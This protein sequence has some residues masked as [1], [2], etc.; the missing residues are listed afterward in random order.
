MKITTTIYSLFLVLAFMVV[1]VTNSWA[2]ATIEVMETDSAAE[3][4]VIGFFDLRERETYMQVTNIDQNPAGRTFHIQ[5]FNVGNNC[6]ENNFFDDYT[7]NDTHVYNIRDI[8]RND[9]TANTV[10]LPDDAYG[11]FVAFVVG[12]DEP[13][14]IGNLRI[15]DVNGYEYRT[16]LPGIEDSPDQNSDDDPSYFNINSESG[17]ILSDIVVF[18][19]NIKGNDNE[20]IMSSVISIWTNWEIDIIDLNEDI[21][22]CRNV[23]TACVE[24]DNPIVPQLLEEVFDE[25][26]QSAGTVASFEWGINE[27]IPS[28]KGAPLLCPGNII[29]DGVVQMNFRDKGD[30]ADKRITVFV[31]L[32][33]GN[34]RGSMDV[35]VDGSTVNND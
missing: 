22:S 33:N 13:V 30:G 28:S 12:N 10:V 21:S 7:P 16:N 18:N 2:G 29:T 4:G 15:L 5:L 32:N 9:G 20:V 23:V 31:G 17:V 25:V 19:A 3:E 11:I 35:F 24:E 8:I 14:I 26:G 1:P 6:N 34:G 27:A